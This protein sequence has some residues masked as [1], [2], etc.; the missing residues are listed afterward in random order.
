LTELT[1]SQNSYVVTNI[2]EDAWN[3]G[4]PVAGGTLAVGALSSTMEDLQ[5]SSLSGWFLESGPVA[6]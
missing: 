5:Q 6:D 2:T 1:T 3:Y 4:T